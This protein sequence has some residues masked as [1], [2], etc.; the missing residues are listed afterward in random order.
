MARHRD[1]RSP[2]PAGSHH[3]SKRVKREDDV[4]RERDRR[5]DVRPQRRRS[6]SRSIDRRHR[7]RDVPRRRDRSIDRR[8]ED[9]YRSGRRDRSRDRR[10]RFDRDRDRSPDRR[11]RRSRDRDYRDSRGDGN[12]SKSAS[13]PDNARPSEPAKPSGPPAQTEAEKKAERLAKLEAWKKK[14]AEDKERKEKELAIGGTRKLLDEID[15]KTNGTPSVASPASPSTPISLASPAPYAGKFDPKAIAKKAVANSSSTSTLGKDLPLKELTKAS[16]TLTSS[17]KGLQADKKTTAFNSTSKASALPKAR[18]NLNAFGLGA[19]SATDSEKPT[20]KR[21]LDFGEEDDARKK[22]EKLP[23]LPLAN[24]ED[25]DAALANVAEEE[26]DDDDVDMEDAGTEEEAAAAARAAAEKR[27]ERL[28][29][30]NLAKEADGTEEST[31]PQAETNGDIKME[32]NLPAQPEPPTVEEDDEIDPLEAFMEQMGDPFA[33]PK[34]TETFN[35]GKSKSQKQQP[36]ALFGDDD[37]DLKAVEADPDDILAM[38]SKVRKKKELP[39][40]NYAKLDLEPVRKNFYTEPAELADMTEAELADLRLEL[41]GIKVAGKDVPKPVQKWS[42]CGLNVQSLE[43]I[44]KLGYER[45]TAIQMQAIPAIMSGRD[46]IGVAKTGSGKTIAFLLPMF[47]HIRDQRP[48]EGS[49][50]PIGLIV[51]PTREL[52]TQIHKECKPFL[53]AMGLRAVCAYGGAPIKDQIADLKRGAEIIVCTPGRMIDLLAANSGRVT[54][55]RRVTYVVLDEADRMF[56][57]GFEPQV[58]K[59]FANIRPDR[60]TILFSAT[61]PRIMDALAKKT[62]QS[63]VEITVGGRSVVAPE[64]TQMVEVREEKEKFHRLLELLGELYNDDEDARTLIFVDRQEK[65]DDLLKDLMRKGYPCM[66]IHGGK[67]QI[68]RDSTIDDFKAGVVPIMIATSVAARGL[69]VKQLKLVVNF[70][71]PNHLEDYVHRA[72]RTGRAGAKGTAVTFITEEQEQY[73]VGIAK[74]LEQSGQPVPERLNEMRKSFRD[75]VKTGKSKD[76]SGFGGKGLERLDAE[77]EAARNRERKTHKTD[78]DDEEE[79]D[80][81]AGDEDIVL[82][83]A[84]TVQ[85]ASAAPTPQLYGV[86]KG[87]DLDGKITVHRTETAVSSGGGSK[88]PLDKVTSAIDAIN[89]RL[90]KTGQLRSGVPIDNKG[91]DAGAFHATLEINDFPQ[92]ARWAV[93]NRTNVAKILEATGTS[94]TTKGSFYPAG[95]EVQAGGDPK[96]YIL[97]EGDTEVVV[98]NAMRELMRLLKEGTMAAAD[99]EGRAPASGRYNVV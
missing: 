17:V 77:R 6:R 50:G 91:P 23:T 48:L 62:L 34:T 30:Q 74:A 64:I 80:D 60:Q 42:Q 29:E 68:D 79:K 5:D 55:L 13:K 9:F 14:M 86:P 95:K 97:V 59:I 16:A 78:G 22:L 94:I 90:N 88:N 84:S 70:D 12:F 32:D 51:T 21:T 43:V 37:V 47:R 20:S 24:I 39:T 28:Q 58:M 3:S 31:E 93:T 33:A 35:K 67:D 36:E 65:A 66:S 40:I 89:A 73:S 61:M 54:N 76:S 81:K 41:D 46:V 8:E 92:K 10:D 69:D 27:E 96:L 52:A 98:T 44:R 82:K 11:R 7:D 83:A 99:A 2:S 19:K 38:A 71:A 53:K 45:P 72:G 56:D 87:I 18:G 26:D 85:P 57:M 49:D 75:K 1:S 25:D 63:P 4:R 15:Q